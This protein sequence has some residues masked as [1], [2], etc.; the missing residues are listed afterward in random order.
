MYKSLTEVEF[1]RKYLRTANFI[2]IGGKKKMLI[3]WLDLG[4]LSKEE[5]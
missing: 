3:G 2:Q 1:Q 5:C 4:I